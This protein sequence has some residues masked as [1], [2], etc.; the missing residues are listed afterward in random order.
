MAKRG[1]GSELTHDNWDQEE[2]REEAGEF[3]K[4][5]EDQMKGRVIKK[6]KRRNLNEDQKKNVFAGFGG[7][8]STNNTPT[9]DAFSFLSANSSS[10]NK[11]NGDTHSNG[12]TFGNEAAKSDS[13]SKKS[14]ETKSRDISYKNGDVSTETE[15]AKPEEVDGADKEP[16]PTA[17]LVADDIFAKFKQ[18]AVGSWTCEICMI[19]NPADKLKCMACET[20][21]PGAAP[22]AAVV[23]SAESKPPALSFGANGGFKFDCG[24]T[25]TSSTP[26]L[27]SG[28]FGSNKTQSFS[29]FKF[30]SAATT[31]SNG[32]KVSTGFKFGTTEGETT[33]KPAFAFG[34]SLNTTDSETAG[35]KFGD[36]EK[37]SAETAKIQETP[38]KSSKDEFLGSLKSLNIQVTNWIKSHVDSFPLV[39]LSPIF[40]DYQMHLKDLRSRHNIPD[41]A[42]NKAPV[43][44]ETK[45]FTFG[46]TEAVDLLG[47]NQFTGF[48]STKQTS[49]NDQDVIE[50]DSPK[51]DI[52]HEEDA[53]YVKKCKLFYKKDDAYIERGLGKVYLKQTEEEKLQV[54]IRAETTLGNI[55][56]NVIVSEKTPLERVGKNNVMLI[57]VPN[58]PLDPK[59]A[60]PEP[61][62]F[63]I[64]VK[65]EQDA[66]ELKQKINDFAK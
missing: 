52:V 17:D 61:V 50:K 40:T 53:V 44:K 25:N 14:E 13:D 1:A 29:G 9:M 45:G 60:D 28:D 2:E 11:P 43:V 62:T 6:A 42:E 66:D 51:K 20:P 48:G 38:N 12:F 57:I 4:A 37:N 33:P 34:S 46:Q 31:Q 49:E 39:D 26:S 35:F 8:S 23:E 58:P 16:E 3:K 22:P 36:A 56:L 7:F 32:D 41:P 27:F 19:T 47:S 21:K 10:E 24:T 63:L 65:T 18:K 15:S 55:L 64:R 59:I 30:G 54:V 5:S